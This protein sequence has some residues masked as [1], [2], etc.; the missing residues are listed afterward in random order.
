ML[1]LKGLPYSTTHQDVMNFFAGFR[2]RRVEFVLE[3]DGRPSGLVS[4]IKPPQACLAALS[5]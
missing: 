2:V 3:A 5:G 4:G 1:K